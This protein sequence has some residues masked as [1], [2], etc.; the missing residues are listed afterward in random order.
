M[1]AGRAH[2]AERQVP[3]EHFPLALA[4][5]I[6]APDV[7]ERLSAAVADSYHGLVGTRN[8]PT[9]R[10]DGNEVKRLGAH[11]DRRQL[12]PERIVVWESRF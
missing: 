10:T 8:D 9:V 12:D 11:A 3:V 5:G 4:Q 6:A 1:A 2:A 7:R